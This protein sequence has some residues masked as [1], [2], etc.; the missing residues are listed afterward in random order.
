VPAADADGQPVRPAAFGI[1]P[2][3]AVRGPLPVIDVKVSARFQLGIGPDRA[4][5]GPRGAAEARPL[6]FRDERGVGP[7]RR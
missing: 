6:S 3:R 5:R 4:V 2:D 1:G 7:H